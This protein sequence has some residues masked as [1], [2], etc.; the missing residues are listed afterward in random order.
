MTGDT[1]IYKP[2]G[3]DGG[4]RIGDVIE[5]EVGLFVKVVEVKPENEYLVV[6]ELLMI[7]EPSQYEAEKNWQ[8][9]TDNM[10]LDLILSAGKD[11]TRKLLYIETMR[12]VKRKYNYQ[13]L[14]EELEAVR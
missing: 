8:E 11:E 14:Q 3:I 6:E 13:T 10:L 12:Y 7:P 5:S 1:H 9:E 2:K 4:Y